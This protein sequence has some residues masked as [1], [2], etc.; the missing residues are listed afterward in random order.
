MRRPPG[1]ADTR[2]A[3]AWL[4]EAVRPAMGEDVA[5]VLPRVCTQA[6]DRALAGFAVAVPHR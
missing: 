4:F 3:S 5:L 1:I 2:F 6:M